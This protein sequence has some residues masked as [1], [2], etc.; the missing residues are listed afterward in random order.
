VAIKTKNNVGKI[1][2]QQTKFL[3]TA[4]TNP[5]A[6]IVTFIWEKLDAVQN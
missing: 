5:A 1:F 3:N 6:Q 4:Y 2:S